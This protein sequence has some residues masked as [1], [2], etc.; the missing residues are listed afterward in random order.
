V[1][2]SALTVSDADDTNLEGAQ[3]QVEGFE[4]GDDLVWVNQLNISG[5]FDSE[6]GVLTVSGSAPVAD[7]ETAL[8]SIKFRHFGDNQS[9][10]R[11]IAFKVNDGDL[12]SA[13]AFKTIDIVTP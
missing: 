1:V 9:A 10:F 13:F 7:Y 3:V 11:P 2:D 4:P 8:R 5:G 12:D 6:V